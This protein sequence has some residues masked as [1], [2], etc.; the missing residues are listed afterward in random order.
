MNR[1]YSPA[2]VGRS[3]AIAL[4]SSFA[5]LLASCQSTDWGQRLGRAIAPQSPPQNEPA[6]SSLTQTEPT[7]PRPAVP[8]A[9]SASDPTFDGEPT[10]TQTP[11]PSTTSTRFQDLD[12]APAAREAVAALD[13]LE[14]FDEVAGDRFAPNR[15][16]RRGEFARWV[17]R[18]NNALYADRPARHI[19]LGKPTEAPEFLDVP[20]DRPD[21]IYIQALA[22]AGLVSGDLDGEFQPD[23]LLSR[24]ELIR[25]KA[26]IDSIPPER[27]EAAARQTVRNL[28]GFSDVDE[29]PANAL[30]ALI[31]DADLGDN[32]TLRRTFGLI[33]AFGSQTPVTRGEAAI[34]LAEF[35]SDDERRNAIEVA[36]VNLPPAVTDP[37]A[38][39]AEPSAEERA[40]EPAAPAPESSVEPALESPAETTEE[41][42]DTSVEQPATRENSDREPASSGGRFI[43]DTAN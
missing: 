39:P 1:R 43:T 42:A 9:E 4:A 34:A 13:T 11:T 14:V 26:A 5:L 33:R 29:I 17:V 35:G 3:G 12:E 6:S 36:G 23:K 16:L 19:R 7:E 38:S 2:R 10:L 40:D 30:D 37:A 32:S 8:P 18:A 21:F 15:S 20:E 22:H 27:D 41:N 24:A 25:I 31:A 28:W